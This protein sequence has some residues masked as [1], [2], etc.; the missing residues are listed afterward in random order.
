MKQFKSL[1]V[2]NLEDFLLYGTILLAPFLLLHI[3]VSCV[4]AFLKPDSTVLIGS[5]IL[6][7]LIALIGFLSA[8]SHTSLSF[9]Q[10]VT[11]GC[12]RKRALFL[13]FS[14]ALCQ[15]ALSL[16][17]AL[18]LAAIER[19]FSFS[20]FQHFAGN[21]IYS[22]LDFTVPLWVYLLVALGGIL[23]GLIASAVILRFGRTG[24]WVL[25]AIFMAGCFAP[26]YFP[27]KQYNILNWLIP[28]LIVAVLAALVWSAYTLLRYS[29]R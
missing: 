9:K 16:V 23:F 6:V 1:F 14:L 20:L 11:F 21:P 22:E 24:G 8:F 19:R 28:M 10:C 13:T 18:G 7:L 27:W 17:L 12:N 29:I 3:V 2:L 26:Q 15:T 25:Y 4:M 5:F